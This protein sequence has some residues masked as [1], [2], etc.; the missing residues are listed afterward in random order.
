MTNEIGNRYGRLTVIE[1]ADNIGPYA[2][3]KCSCDCGGETIVRGQALRSGT[4]KSCGCIGLMKHGL[5]RDPEYKYA[6]KILRKAKNNNIPIFTNDVSVL[7]IWLLKNKWES[8]CAISLTD[9]KKGYYPD[10]MKIV[11]EKDRHS[12]KSNSKYLTLDG[13]TKTISQWAKHLGMSRQTLHV[14]LKTGWSVERALT[15]PLIG[16][17]K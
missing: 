11:S 14:R 7:I 13:Q 4:T 5:S 6:C 16:K 15:T 1:R 2:A 10:N 8:G 9:A 12:Q 3:W 17:E